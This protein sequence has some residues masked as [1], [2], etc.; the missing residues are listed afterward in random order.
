[1]ER[2][3]KIKDLINELISINATHGDIP[4]MKYPK[5]EIKKYL[6]EN[7]RCF[8]E[9]E[10]DFDIN[11]TRIPMECFDKDYIGKCLIIK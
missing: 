8:F 3:L 2:T 1:M 7:G 11:G 9:K 6:D 10:D 4:L 5:L